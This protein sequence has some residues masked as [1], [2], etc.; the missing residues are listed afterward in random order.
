MNVLGMRGLQS[1]GLLPV[2]KAFVNFNLK[3]L[4]P[5]KIGTNLKNLK[6][7]P[8]APGANPTI[9]TMMQFFVPLPIKPL[10]C[11]RLSCQVYDQIFAGFSQPIIGNFTIPIGELI[12]ELAAERKA[13]LNALK[14]MVATMAKIGKG[15]ERASLLAKSM[16]SMVAEQMAKDGA[17]EEALKAVRMT[18]DAKNKIVAAFD[19]RR[20]ARVQGQA[21]A[22]AQIT[23]EVSVNAD[24]GADSQ[25]LLSGDADDELQM[26]DR[27]IEKQ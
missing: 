5:P 21:G 20:A 15:E 8:K 4:V 16:R 12:H 26:K 6:T 19:S 22:P 10:Y 1:T 9:N 11:P 7:D 17:S 14:T 25:P 18:P 13:E 27:L 24:V 2:K 23:E 3:G